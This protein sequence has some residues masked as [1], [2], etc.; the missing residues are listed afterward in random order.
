MRIRWGLRGFVALALCAGAWPGFGE[1]PKAAIALETPAFDSAQVASGARLAAI[2]NCRTCH[3]A[4]GGRSFAG[5]RPFSTPYGTLYASNITP[6]PA[7]G[8]GHW[9]Y[10]DF[11]RAM[12]EGVG[13]DGR[14]LYPA[15]PYDHF[16]RLT[17]ADVAALYA[18]SMTREP[19]EAR[20][21]PNRLTFPVNF[22]PLLAM[23]KSLYFE[24]G[25]FTPDPMHSAEWN[26]GAYLVEGLAHCGAC[27]TPRNAAGAEK[28]EQPLTGGEADG[29]Y[30]PALA[31]ASLSPAPWTT[32]AMDRYLRD[33]FDAQHGLAAGPMAPVV[34][35][36]ASAP[37]SDVRAI[38]LYLTDAHDDTA[39][40]K[41]RNAFDTAAVREYDAV[42]RR[43]P[44]RASEASAAAAATSDAGEIVFSG[45]CATCHYTAGTS[46]TQGPVPLALASSVNAPDARNALRVVLH[47]LHPTSGDAGAVMPGFAGALT[48]AQ[49]VAVVQYMRARFSDRPR[50][51]DVD[52][53]LRTLE[54]ENAR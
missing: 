44:D 12:H 51:N 42:G 30:A 8:I 36:L 28:K 20:P 54:R 46:A 53:T 25:R 40:A 2:G 50:W 24:P 15:F 35:N 17:D 37:A 26:R 14:H 32:D 18:Y 22:R 49:V 45:A 52:E 6:D 47:G 23:W 7:T 33:G 29:W 3:T 34:D 13:R 4:D 48:D 31:A 9:S 19:V 10:D 21:P 1:A 43:A 27:H 5:G 11:R 39:V 16:T 38:A 41:A